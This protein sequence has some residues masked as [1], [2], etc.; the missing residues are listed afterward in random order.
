[1][2]TCWWSVGPIG[3]PWGTQDGKTM[4]ASTISGRG[5]ET[6]DVVQLPHRRCAEQLTTFLQFFAN[7]TGFATF[8]S[9]LGKVGV[10]AQ[11]STKPVN[12]KK[13]ISPSNH[14][15]VP[16]WSKRRLLAI[17]FDISCKNYSLYC[18]VLILA[19]RQT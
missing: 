3:E 18:I 13:L 7:L 1:M 2:R 14:D 15:Q 11:V 16:N 12:V 4:M 10:I 17:L 6:D 9:Q 19:C 5:E 8:Y